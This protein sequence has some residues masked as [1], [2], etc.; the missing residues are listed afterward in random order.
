[1]QQIIALDRDEFARLATDVPLGVGLRALEQGT[2]GT[3]L[4][5]RMLL[6]LSRMSLDAAPLSSQAT[7][8][9]VRSA[10]AE[11]VFTLLREI[12]SGL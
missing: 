1:M 8:D 9:K 7:A 11:G 5:T 3:G 4:A 12:S 6:S 2:D 10:A